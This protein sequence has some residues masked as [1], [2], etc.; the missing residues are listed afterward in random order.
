MRKPLVTWSSDNS[1]AGPPKTRLPPAVNKSRANTGTDSPRMA[2]NTAPKIV[3]RC[4][5]GAALVVIGSSQLLPRRTLLAAGIAPLAIGQVACR[6]IDR[7]PGIGL[8]G[9]GDFVLVEDAQTVGDLVVRQ[10]DS[11][12]SENAVAAGC[13]QI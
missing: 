5:L 7:G 12:P 6:V 3:Q 2:V 4:L 11:R 1:I 8:G 13:Q 10:F 9:S